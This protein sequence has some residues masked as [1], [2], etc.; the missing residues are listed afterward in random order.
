MQDLINVRSGTDST[1]TLEVKHDINKVLVLTQNG[2]HIAIHKDE[3]E[4]I[5]L[6]LIYHYSKSYLKSLKNWFSKL[7]RFRKN[8]SIG[9]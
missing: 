9:V 4:T 2:I 8:G 3:A 1:L 6:F 5:M 7:N